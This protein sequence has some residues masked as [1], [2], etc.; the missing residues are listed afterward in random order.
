[1]AMYGYYFMA[2]YSAMKGYVWLRIASYGYVGLY[3]A[4]YV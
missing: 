4:I 3:R 2:M 1:M